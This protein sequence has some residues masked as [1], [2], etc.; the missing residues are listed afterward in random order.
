[1]Y[2]LKSIDFLKVDC[3][4]AEYE[5]FYTVSNENMLKIKEMLIEYHTH[6]HVDWREQKDKL[7]QYLTIHNFET[8]EFST[9]IHAKW[10]K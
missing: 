8:T 3:E 2:S 4:G 5:I 10:K 7:K 6:L 1:M 9:Y